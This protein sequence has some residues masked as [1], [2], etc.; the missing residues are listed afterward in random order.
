MKENKVVYNGVSMAPEWP[1]KI[2]AA[3]LQTTYM[4]NGRLFNRIR[5]G[6]EPD[7]QGMPFPPCHDC[8]VLRGQYHVGPLC[9][10]ECCPCC[11][12]QVLSCDCEYEGD[13]VD[14]G[15]CPFRTL[16]NSEAAEA[17]AMTGS[18]EALISRIRARLDRLPPDL[19]A[20]RQAATGVE[21]DAIR[22]QI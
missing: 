8:G 4:I 7:L 19:Q 18:R 16:H 22:S 3:Q 13:D 11:G 5:Y 2:E 1:A 14:N 17:Q 10:M 21:Q 6:D 12:G 20:V 9:D 15:A